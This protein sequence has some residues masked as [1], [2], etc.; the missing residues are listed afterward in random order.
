MQIS[1]ADFNAGIFKL[2]EEFR[3]QIDTKIWLL[4]W[5]KHV[6]RELFS[7]VKVP[8]LHFWLHNPMV[9]C[10][11]RELETGGVYGFVYSILCPVPNNSYVSLTLLDVEV[12]HDSNHH[13][14]DYVLALDKNSKHLDNFIFSPIIL[15]GGPLGN[16]C[17]GVRV[18][19]WKPGALSRASRHHTSGHLQK[20]N[21][22]P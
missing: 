12:W 9:R 15:G 21:R 17:F 6:V 8:S 5:M 20:V 1:I 10:W 19:V 2:P 16:L 11:S 4:H 7:N 3:W 18:A 22:L 13:S 14:R